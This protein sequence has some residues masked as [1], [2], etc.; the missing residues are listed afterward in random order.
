MHW[1]SYRSWI[2]LHKDRTLRG[3]KQ[4][5]ETARERDELL[6]IGSALQIYIKRDKI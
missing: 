6:L 2:P 5:S 3:D 1:V 4:D